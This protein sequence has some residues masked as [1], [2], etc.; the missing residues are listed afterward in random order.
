MNPQLRK[1]IVSKYEADPT[2]SSSG[3]CKY[4]LVPK[5]E[6]SFHQFGVGY[7]EFET[8]AGNFSTAIVEWPDGT[9]ENIPAMQVKFVL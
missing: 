5:G 2:P 3:R 7:E 9:V 6:A 8:G 1:V 4:I